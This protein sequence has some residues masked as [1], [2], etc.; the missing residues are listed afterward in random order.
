MSSKRHWSFYETRFQKAGRSANIDIL[1][2]YATYVMKMRSSFST[3][4]ASILA[5][6]S[7][8][9]DY[10]NCNQSLKY[11]EVSNSRT[12]VWACWNICNPL[13]QIRD[14]VKRYT[15]ILVT[16]GNEYYICREYVVH[17][18]CICNLLKP[19]MSFILML[20]R[21][22][23]NTLY[24]EW[25]HHHHHQNRNSSNNCDL[26]FCIRS[27]CASSPECKIQAGNFV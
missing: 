12:H 21:T 11:Q 25:T 20:Y 9:V 1:I 22:S 2:T 14:A 15:F 13:P 23:Q 17:T 26:Q 27:I 24:P 4:A 18:R 5:K 19:F 3:T 16:H 6:L 10:Y 7:I 8:L